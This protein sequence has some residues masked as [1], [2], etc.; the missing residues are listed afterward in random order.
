MVILALFPCC[1]D[2]LTLVEVVLGHNTVQAA[3]DQLL[4][5]HNITN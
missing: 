1:L 4:D 2:A 3:V 5:A